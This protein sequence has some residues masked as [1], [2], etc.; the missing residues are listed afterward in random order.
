MQENT[1]FSSNI[2]LKSPLIPLNLNITIS[3]QYKKDTTDR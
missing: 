3:A 1:H 2:A